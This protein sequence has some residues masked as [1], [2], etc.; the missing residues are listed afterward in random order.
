MKISGIVK[1]M[2]TMSVMVAALTGCN[3]ESYDD[4]VA[5]IGTSPPPAV[6][7]P[8]G[9]PPPP[10]PP[11]PPGG[12]NPTLAD[13]QTNVFTPT[14]ASSSCHGGGAPAAGLNLTDGASYA[15]LVGITSPQEGSLQ[16]VNPNN[17]D[18]SYLIQKMEGAAGIA[19]QVM[20][21]SGPIAQTSIDTIRQWITDGAMDD[22]VAAADPIQVSSIA[23]SPNVTLAAPPTQIVAGFTREPVAAS[24][25]ANTFILE[26]S[27]GDG[28]F[29]DGT[30]VQIMSPQISIAV[31]NPQ[32]AVFDLSGVVMADD[33]YRIRL[34]GDGASVIS[35][36]DA[37]ALDGE[38]GVTFPSGNGTAG[39]DFQ[40]FFTI[41]TPV[42]S[43]P[44]LPQIQATVF[45]PT[46]ATVGCHTGGGAVLPG[47]LDL[48]SEANSLANLVNIAATQDNGVFR[49]NP[50]NPD[51]SYLITK[52]E[53]AGAIGVQMPLGQAPL[54]PA[55]IADI[56]LWITNGANP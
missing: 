27:G 24:V 56:R 54:D 11:P 35:D 45:T 3:V 14:C 55:V 47:V 17:P 16:L 18:V 53:S 23:P 34:L 40:T 36:I 22:P 6:P 30:V 25:D 44:T 4:A 5:R 9:P 19:G 49:V 31:G 26:S 52:L 41:T 28:S 46:C 8:P 32:S 50:G 12:F 29:T 15:A 48:S 33:L 37:N 21:Q 20:P 2:V 51:M 7:P 39:G 10:P 38:F 13:I 1:A 42:V 43:G